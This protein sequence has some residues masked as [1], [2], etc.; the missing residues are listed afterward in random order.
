MILKKCESPKGYK[1]SI[2]IDAD[3]LI[4]I[5]DRLREGLDIEALDTLHED[6][7]KDLNIHKKQL[8]LDS[9][10]CNINDVNH[11]L[12]K[13]SEYFN[14]SKEAV[15]Y[16]LKNEKL[17]IIENNEPQRIRSVFRGYR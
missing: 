17:L 14:V 12:L 13:L 3:M 7:L 1:W 9:Q 16:R 6:C 2:Y 8:Y 10:P 4:T 15:K 11:A 5:E